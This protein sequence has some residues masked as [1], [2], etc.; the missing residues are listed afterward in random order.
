M[1]TKL[2][3]FSLSLD[4]IEAGINLEIKSSFQII[5]RYASIDARLI[6]V[7]NINIFGIWKHNGENEQ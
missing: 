5:E 4:S 2:K 1:K 6:F 3:N 7:I